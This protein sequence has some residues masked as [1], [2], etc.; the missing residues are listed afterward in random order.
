MFLNLNVLATEGAIFTSGL[1]ARSS[2]DEIQICNTGTG[3]PTFDEMH[4]YN[5]EK[6]ATEL[7]NDA[8]SSQPTFDDDTIL[9]MHFDNDLDAGN[10]P[11]LGLAVTDWR[12]L[13]REQGETSFIFLTEIPNDSN[14]TYYDIRGESGST[15]EYAIQSV[16]NGTRGGVVV[17]EAISLSFY[18]W[19]LTSTDYNEIDEIGEA[20]KFFV[21]TE[22]SAIN[23][24][25]DR[26]V[27]RTYST[28]PK[29][30][31]GEQEY[32]VG[33]ITGFPITEDENG[34]ITPMGNADKKALEA[35]L[36]NKE[37]KIL[38]DGSGDVYAVDIETDSIKYFDNLTNSEFSTNENE[39]PFMATFNWIE[40]EDPIN[41]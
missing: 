4:F 16:S 36:R 14:N 20:Y 25:K 26:S 34:C 38:R 21:E 24:E 27:Y 5:I 2:Y 33:A 30:S 32:R 22:S 35:F 13:K 15:T 39:Q 11:T 37:I 3:T 41:L 1:P 40:V 31:Y 9:L 10:F 23:I 28:F 12:V 18:G 19:I 17:S 29:V 8:L 6:T 7:I